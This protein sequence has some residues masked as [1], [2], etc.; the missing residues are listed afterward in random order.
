MTM[1]KNYTSLRCRLP[2]TVNPLT[3]FYHF[4]CISQFILL[5]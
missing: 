1:S 4:I 3:N 2:S 5:Q